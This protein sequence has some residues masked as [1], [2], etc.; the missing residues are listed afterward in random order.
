[1]VIDTTK[2]AP[3]DLVRNFP[4][5]VNWDDRY[6]DALLEGSAIAALAVIAILGA[7]IGSVIAAVM[8]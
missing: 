6:D 4:A 2:L 7:I 1:M 8:L 3:D 5:E